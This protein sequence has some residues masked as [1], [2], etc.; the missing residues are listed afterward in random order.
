MSELRACAISYALFGVLYASGRNVT[1]VAVLSLL[2]FVS[3]ALVCVYLAF[4]EFH[5]FPKLRAVSMLIATM[6]AGVVTHG[7]A[8]IAA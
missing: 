3:V 6:S 5:G 8:N 4:N 7:I 1:T 2:Y